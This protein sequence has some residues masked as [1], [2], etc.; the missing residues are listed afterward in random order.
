MG[1]T[2]LHLSGL[3]VCVAATALLI[4]T[5]LGTT[6]NSSFLPNVYFV[7]ANF[8]TAYIRFGPYNA[9][10]YNGGQ[11]TCT[12]PKLAQ[13]F[14][15]SSFNIPNVDT[16]AVDALQTAYKFIVLLIPCTV[17]AFLSLT[18]WMTIR[19]HRN[20]N[21]LPIFG[22]I[23]SLLGLICGAA[24]LALVIVCHQVPFNLLQ[25]KTSA[26]TYQ[27]GTSLYLLGVG[28]VGCM[29]ISFILYVTSAIVHKPNNDYTYFQ[30]E[31][32]YIDMTYQSDQAQAEHHRPYY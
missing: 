31:E 19:R 4:I 5:N 2:L 20:S 1:G 8:A 24:T 32:D 11:V 17:L 23:G 28:G 14:D 7:Q 15:L 13:T 30:K 22:A 16:S 25:S 12:A 26:L 27:W 18:G 21:R 3:F 29:L 10:L 9:C 6:F